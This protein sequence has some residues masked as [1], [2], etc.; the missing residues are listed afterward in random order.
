MTDH[1]HVAIKETFMKL[2]EKYS[3]HKPKMANKFFNIKNGID[4]T[5]GKWDNFTKDDYIHFTAKIIFCAHLLSRGYL[6]G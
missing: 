4:F 6:N 5:N 1:D 2:A 3:L